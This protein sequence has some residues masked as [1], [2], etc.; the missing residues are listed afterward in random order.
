[1]K[2]ATLFPDDDIHDSAD[3]WKGSSASSADRST[4]R[5]PPR[6]S[7]ST[8]AVHGRKFGNDGTASEAGAVP[9]DNGTLTSR[10]AAESVRPC[11]KSQAAR[12]WAYIESQGER[13]ATDKEIQAGL[14]M[15]GNS[16]RPRRVWLMRNGFVKPK[17]AP[18][19]HVVR[20]RSIVWV[21]A[22]RL[23]LAEA[24]GRAGHEEPRTGS[25]TD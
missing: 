15:D 17:D 18:C 9:Y 16:Q 2:A 20:D 25:N 14:K 13:G 10:T 22:K 24:I 23:E 19:E 6:K 12:V 3:D 5:P 8:P 11:V 1:M 21:A 7:E 4:R